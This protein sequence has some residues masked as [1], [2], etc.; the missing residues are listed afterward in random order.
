MNCRRLVDLHPLKTHGERW[1]P[2]IDQQPGLHRGNKVDRSE[3]LG[4]VVVAEKNMQRLRVWA[5]KI[6]WYGQNKV[7]GFHLVHGTQ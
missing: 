1:R 2:V 3:R 4:N 7:G 5:P 6:S